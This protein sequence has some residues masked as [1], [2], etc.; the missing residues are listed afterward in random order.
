MFYS[1]SNAVLIDLDTSKLIAI[2][3][4]RR[5]EIVMNQKKIELNGALE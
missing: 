3:S 5:E 1:R 4:V 2:L